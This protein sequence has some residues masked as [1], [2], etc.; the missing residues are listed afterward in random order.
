MRYQR[1]H[2]GSNYVKMRDREQREESQRTQ[3]SRGEKRD[4]RDLKRN[5]QDQQK[6]FTCSIS[7]LKKQHSEDFSSKRNMQ[8]LC[9]SFS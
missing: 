5:T 9:K 7:K 3:N 1:N 4:R 6:H 8:H 2:F